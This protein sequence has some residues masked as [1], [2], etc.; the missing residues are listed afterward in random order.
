MAKSVQAV[1][2]DAHA[3]NATPS[4]RQLDVDVGNLTVFDP[5]PCEVLASADTAAAESL[6]VAQRLSQSLVE[7]LYGLPFDQVPEGRIAK[8]PESTTR[9][10]RE[11]PLP[12]ARALT[13]WQKFAQKKGIV[14]RKKSKL[15]WDEVHQEWR[16]SHGY[17]KAND[18]NA[19]PIIEARDMDKAGEDPFS[20]LATTKKAGVKR[21]KHNQV[22]NVKAALKAG[23]K[24]A[25]PA[26]LQLASALPQSSKQQPKVQPN[27]K[28]LKDQIKQA[29]LLSGISTASMGKFD[30]RLRGEKEGERVAPGKRRKFAAVEDTGTDRQRMLGLAD[31]F[32]RERADDVVDVRKA[33]GRLEADA[34]EE[35]HQAKARGHDLSSKGKVKGKRAAKAKGKSGRPERGSKGPKR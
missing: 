33:I 21:Q 6:T 14:K 1:A 7:H 5:C 29:S 10:P 9:L 31:R 12:K 26:T 3:T 11:K 4:G 2:S 27:R 35:R 32:L 19:V 17:K 25:I 8:L 15:V 16:R 18:E 24:H 13:A 28:L 30:K 23:G 20:E 34:R 22:A